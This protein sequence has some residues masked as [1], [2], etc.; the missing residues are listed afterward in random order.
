VLTIA[1]DVVTAGT[2]ATANRRIFSGQ[3][4]NARL[5]T[6]NFGPMYQTLRPNAA[7]TLTN[8]TGAY[9]DIDADPDTTPVTDAGLVPVVDP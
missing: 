3:G 6:P 7:L 5:V 2:G 1:M 8:F 4:A 9:T